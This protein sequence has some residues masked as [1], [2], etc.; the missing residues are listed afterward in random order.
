MYAVYINNLQNAF[1]HVLRCFTLFWSL[2]FSAIWRFSVFFFTVDIHMFVAE[3]DL[4]NL[5][6]TTLRILIMMPIL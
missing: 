1:F 2:I 3:Y 6:L 4:C 5:S